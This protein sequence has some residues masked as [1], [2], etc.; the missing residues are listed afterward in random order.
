MPF[1]LEILL[2]HPESGAC[3]AFTGRFTG[4]PDVRVIR[5][6]FEDLEPHDAFVTAGNAFGIMTAGVDAAVVRVLGE[7]IMRRVQERIQD[8]FLGEQSVAPGAP[9]GVAGNGARRSGRDEDADGAFAQRRKV[10]RG[11]IVCNRVH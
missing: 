8:E 1:P 10:L 5:A 7:K 2:I 9:G 4:L 6:R 11:V 3:A